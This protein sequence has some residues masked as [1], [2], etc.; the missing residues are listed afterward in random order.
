M[1]DMLLQW[2][3]RAPL[4]LWGLFYPLLPLLWSW[5]RPQGARRFIDRA[6]WPWMMVPADPRQWR[7]F[8]FAALAWWLGW[9]CLLIA[10]AGPRL[11]DND[12]RVGHT[13]LRD[14]MV[15]VDLSRSMSAADVAPNRLRRARLE[16][17]SWLPMVRRSRLGLVVY[18][19]RPHLVAPLTDD[20]Q[21]FR[22]YLSAIDEGLLPTEGSDPL[23]ALEL[24]LGQISPRDRRP[25]ALLLLSDGGFDRSGFRTAWASLESRLSSRGIPLYVL[26]IGTSAGSP[27]LG[28]DGAWLKRDGAPVLSRLHQGRLRQMAADS[29]GR[30]HQVADD[31][32]DWDELYRDGMA[33]MGRGAASAGGEAEQLWHDYHRPWLMAAAILLFLSLLRRRTAS[34]VGPGLWMLAGLSVLM[35]LHSH[36]ALADDGLRQADQRFA[37]QS[38]Q[39]ALDAYARLQGYR[40]RL[41]EGASAYFLARYPHAVR[42]F[43]LAFVA[44]ETDR[45][46]ADAL[47]DLA[48][49]RFQQGAYAAA[50]S[51]YADVL[52]YAP[53]HARAKNNLA[54]ARSLKQAVEQRLRQ[55]DASVRRPGRGLRQGPDDG[56]PPPD[57]VRR[58]LDRQG[59][60]EP[61]A[62]QGSSPN[63]E[64]LI[65]RGVRYSRVVSSAL[66]RAGTGEQQ[67]DIADLA[68]LA[69]RG[70]V[71]G[72]SPSTLWRRLFEAEE[73]F[74]APLE[75]PRPLP[76]RRPW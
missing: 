61:F 52:R 60:T 46:R 24:A 23:A 55:G 74:P 16:L 29:G 71:D 32:S 26:G 31:D 69:A 10:L 6:L 40:A 54:V 51:L 53:A 50:E 25:A 57:G 75:Q 21:A 27:L 63:R 12:Y 30:Y 66:S 5:L 73:D 28:E 33:R 15:V 14:V 68:S 22:H 37:Q 72:R 56:S 49:S 11:P 38:Y 8:P 9:S 41:G 65:E 18:A 7:R 70:G 17:E 3:W 39:S 48:N 45:Q 64:A 35:G 13:A 1:M 67:Y 36:Q 2:H 19:A 59:H 43:T 4:W 62:I 76:G 42:Q 47:Y 58:Q 20:L 44:A 34:R